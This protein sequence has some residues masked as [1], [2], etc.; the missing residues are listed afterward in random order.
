[1]LNLESGLRARKDHTRLL[2]L[3]R[4]ILTLLRVN[5]ANTDTCSKPMYKSYTTKAQCQ[6]MSPNLFYLTQTIS[7]TYRNSSMHTKDYWRE[8]TES[9]ITFLMIQFYPPNCIVEFVHVYLAQLTPSDP[10]L[11]H[12]HI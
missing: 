11:H 10:Q 9:N 1:M 5:N 4:K 3:C 2:A 8:I 6:K 7:Y 12:R